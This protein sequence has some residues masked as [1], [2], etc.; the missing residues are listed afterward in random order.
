MKTGLKILMAAALGFLAGCNGTVDG[1]KP[2][3][4]G[5]ELL[6][7]DFQEGRTLRYRF[8]SRREI[9]LNWGAVEGGARR[10]KDTIDKSS[11]SMDMVVAYTPVKVDPRKKSCR[12]DFHVHCSAYR[13]N[14]G[15]L[16]TGQTD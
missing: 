7:V 6:T 16:R 2:L 12:Q 4:K 11:E 14:G 5:K 13:S 10:G 1:I 15:P 9:T 8:V 3:G